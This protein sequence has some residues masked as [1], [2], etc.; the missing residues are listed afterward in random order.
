MKF[1]IRSRGQGRTTDPLEWARD[2]TTEER[3]IAALEVGE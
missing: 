1:D 2:H 3:V